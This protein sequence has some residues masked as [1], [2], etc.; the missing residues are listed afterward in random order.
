MVRVT[1]TESSLPVVLQLPEGH[2]FR[3]L[4]YLRGSGST[5]PPSLASKP[6]GAGRVQAARRSGPWTR[7]S[8]VTL[9]LPLGSYSTEGILTFLPSAIAWPMPHP[10]YGA[11]AR[12][13]RCGAAYSR[14]DG[15]MESAVMMVRNCLRQSRSARSRIDHAWMITGRGD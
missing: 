4:L 5:P 8:T 1:R 2:G 14:A 13:D 12:L 3:A 7:P 10:W 15:F 11:G 6:P 9:T